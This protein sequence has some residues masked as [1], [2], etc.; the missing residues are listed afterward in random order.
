M[1]SS[2]SLV[3]P[4]KSK[5]GN[6]SPVGVWCLRLAAVGTAGL[7][8]SACGD[9]T[10]V[11]EPGVQQPGA[12]DTPAGAMSRFAAA[13]STFADGYSFQTLGS[14]II[15]DEFTDRSGGL[16]PE[17]RRSIPDEQS[18]PSYPYAEL[19]TARLDALRAIPTLEK[20]SSDST[21]AIAESF[22]VAGFVELFFAE[23]LCSGVPLAAIQNDVPSDATTYSRVALLALAIAHF[24]S[25][26]SRSN[27]ADSIRYTAEVG[28]ARALVDGGFFDSA[29]RTV[30][31][32]PS[33]FIL[34]T[35]SISGPMSV[36]RVAVDI[37]EYF[38]SSVS[39]REGQNGLPF[40][41]ERDPRV[42]LDS[43][44]SGIGGATWGFTTYT[45]L[46][47]PTVI[48]SGLEASLIR[49][50]AAL[51]DGRVT[52]WADTL[53]ALRAAFPDT[54][55]SNHPLPADS[56]TTANSAQQALTMF[57]E[58]AEWL[59]ATGHRQGD[60]RR[61]V[62]QYHFSSNA[63]F[64][65]GV[66]QNGPAQYGSDVTFTTVGDQA[67]AGYTGCSSRAP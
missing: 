63:V 11:S 23:N 17:D 37:R 26:L 62:T 27:S 57:H 16:H 9:L 59:F 54:A 42:P 49:A 7:L 20:Y 67:L 41:S 65:T 10:S 47:A 13:V 28:R 55:L 48:T 8:L 5:V 53:N 32:V 64:P 33:S 24:D 15:A 22:D 46:T 30:S 58:R 4:E 29:A 39:D 21:V 56:T 19:V 61:L 12:F 38:A 35:V 51:W 60:L 40:V 36:N 6:S 44:G 1:P 14:G 34:S 43:V 31:D 45:S 2:N 25:A 66:Y 3:H 52:D 18:Q 50:E